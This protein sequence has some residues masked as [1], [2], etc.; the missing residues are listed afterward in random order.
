MQIIEIKRNNLVVLKNR[1]K[2]ISFVIL[3]P[4]GL[5]LIPCISYA[6]AKKGNGKEQKSCSKEQSNQSEHTVSCK[7]K[8]CK[9]NAGILSTARANTC[10]VLVDPALLH[11]LLVFL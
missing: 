11:L 6:C 5:F 7:D 2:H 8:S 3:M 10:I 1:S 4:P 9:K